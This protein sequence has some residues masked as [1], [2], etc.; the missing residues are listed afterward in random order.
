MKSA[1][2]EWHLGDLEQALIQLQS[3][4]QQFTDYPKFY[5]MQGQI[6]TIQGRLPEARESYNTGTKKCSTNVHLWLL[7]SRLD[8]K[9]GQMTRARS[10]LE[11]ARQK[12]THNPQLWVEAIRLEW[13][14]GLKDIASTL[15]AKAL[16]D[17]PNSGLLWAETIFMADR[18]QRKSKSVDALKKCEHDPHVLLAVSKLFWT[19]RRSVVSGLTEPSRSS[20]T[21]EMLGPISTNLNCCTA[22]RTNRRMYGSVACRL[23]HVT[24]KCGQAFPKRR[25]TGGLKLK[26]FSFWWRMLWLFQSEPWNFLRLFCVCFSLT[27]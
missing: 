10:V 11:K 18:P 13:R 23:S 20:Q 4:V 25:K 21:W 9:Q 12:N 2:L 16:Q 6:Y 27:K 8:E 5:M 14:A 19:E 22:R 15:L 3:A 17:C 1:K 7:L 26:T 24:E